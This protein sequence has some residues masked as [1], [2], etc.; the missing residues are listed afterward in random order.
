MRT[1]LKTTM[2]EAD[3][4]MKINENNAVMKTTAKIAA[5]QAV[6]ILL[7]FGIFAVCGKFTYKVLLGGLLGGVV[8]V[9]NFFF[10]GLSVDSAAD[11]YSGSEKNIK[12]SV[13]LSFIARL[14]VMLLCLGLA[15]KS[16]WFNP[17][18]L[19]VPLCLVRP[20]LLVCE[21]ISKA[22]TKNNVAQSTAGRKPGDRENAASDAEVNSVDSGDGNT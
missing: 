5:G 12:A 4:T 9:L 11:R 22:K 16:G 14:V 1:D 19:L 17:I 7:M 3:F 10:M 20:I 21:F 15:L 2:A 13:Q 8:T 6:C 18:S